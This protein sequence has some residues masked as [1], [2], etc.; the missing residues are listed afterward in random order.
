MKQ[1]LLVFFILSSVSIHAQYYYRDIIIPKTNTDLWEAYKRN[2]IKKVVL[3]S[4]ES[5]GTPT[6]GF[7]GE[8][9]ITKDFSSIV[10]YTASLNAGQAILETNYSSVGK[11]MS[12][13]DSSQGYS[14]RTNYQYD[15]AGRLLSMESQTYS[16]GKPADL[17]KHEWQYDNSGKPIRMIRTKNGA[18]ETIVSFV[19]DDQGN[20]IEE[21]SVRG[22][23]KLP[24][25]YYYYDNVNRLTDIVRYSR[26]AKRLLPDYVFEYDAK[27]KLRSMLI[28]PEGT[29]QYQRWVYEYEADNLKKTESCFD[30]HR[31]LLGRI[32]YTY[33]K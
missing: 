22:A 27:G 4:R 7:T 31:K 21:N 10:T 1:A 33:S 18:D 3:T 20:I 5:D 16:E 9:D 15:E 28:V 13:L 30:K 24:S 26:Q 17:E 6:E 32:E 23:T 14:T 12:S 25:V 2:G 19:K 8:Q 11:I 29:D